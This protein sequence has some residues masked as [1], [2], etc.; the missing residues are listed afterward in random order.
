MRLTSTVVAALAFI[1][2]AA[3]ASA[4]PIAYDDGQDYYAPP[5]PP[6][7]VE[8][9]DPDHH[10]Q[11][12]GALGFLIGAMGI[13]PIN[14]PAYGMQLAGGTRFD[15][16]LLQG[17][18]DFLSVGESS[19]DPNNPDPVRGLMHR[20]GAN[21]RYSFVTLTKHDFPLRG[22]FWLE[23]G[24]GREYLRWYG[25]GKLTRND[26]E[27]GL[28]GQMTVRWGQNKHKKVGLF[29]ALKMTGARRADAKEMPPT[30]AGPCDEPTGP[31]PYDL[32]IFF[33]VAVVFG[34]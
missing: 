32:G 7:K 18:Y 25:G 15:R 21:L 30:C 20:I 8:D 14:G 5:P 6:P 12:E 23:A 13:G 11:P 17:E 1:L 10:V 31:I 22:D 29:Y 4:H 34:R 19:Y 3:A 27:L 28:G 24:V 9:P 26:V 2:P 16:F 33:D